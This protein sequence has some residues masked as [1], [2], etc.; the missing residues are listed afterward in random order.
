MPR[1]NFR[2]FVS[3][4]A[5]VSIVDPKDNYT[6]DS[7]FS[8]F[9]NK[10]TGNKDIDALL[11]SLSGIFKNLD[12]KID[13]IKTRL[14]GQAEHSKIIPDCETINISGSGVLLRSGSRL[15]NGEIIIIRMN[16]FDYPSPL[17]E[18]LG[19]VVRSVSE[20]SAEGCHFYTGIQ[21]INL[22]NEQREKLISYTFH[23]Q[24]KYIRA[25]N[26]SKG[27]GSTGNNL[28]IAENESASGIPGRR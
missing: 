8:G 14:D 18:S 15:E 11:I 16:L 17:F 7:I 12:N 27:T 24:R 6:T 22:E 3:G 28:P 9:I 21:F 4:F 26:N 1:R 25:F 20:P 23:Q 13:S 2:T 19:R 5:E 10:S